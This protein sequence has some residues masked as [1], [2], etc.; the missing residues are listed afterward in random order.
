MSQILKIFGSD[1]TILVRQCLLS[2]FDQEMAS[3]QMKNFEHL[4]VNFQCGQA[5]KIEKNK[6]GSKLVTFTNGKS[7][8]FDCVLMAVGKY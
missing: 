2:T 5:E 4:G 1:T 3:F 8:V 6:D 7:S